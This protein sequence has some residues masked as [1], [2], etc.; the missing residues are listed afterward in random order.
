MCSNSCPLSRWSL[1]TISSSIVSFPSCPH[2]SIWLPISFR[3]L[4]VLFM[5]FHTLIISYVSDLKSHS[6]RQLLP[7]HTYLCWNKFFVT[8]RFILHIKIPLKCLVC[9]FITYTS[10]MDGPPSVFLPIQL[11]SLCKALFIVII[12]FITCG[13]IILKSTNRLTNVYC[14]TFNTVVVS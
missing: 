9:F 1:P 7:K 5:I 6:S 4:S 14:F 8:N 12:W 2:T 13:C 10:T 3:F 11:F